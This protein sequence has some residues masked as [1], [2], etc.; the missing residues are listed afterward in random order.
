MKEIRSRIGLLVVLLL[1]LIPAVYVLADETESDSDRFT[2]NAAEIDGDVQLEDVNGCSVRLQVTN[3]GDD[4]E[5]TL[6]ILRYESVD[7]SYVSAVG[8]TVSIKSGETQNIYLKLSNITYDGTP[9]RI[10]LRVDFLDQDGQLLCRKITDFQAA[11]DITAKVAAGVYTDDTQKLSVIDKSRFRYE[12]TNISGDITM[13]ARQMSDEEMDNIKQ[14]NINLLILDKAISESTWENISEW[15]MYGGHAMMEQSVYQSLISKT[16]DESGLTDWGKGRILVYDASEWKGTMLL[17]SVKSLFGTTGIYALLAGDYGE[18]YWNVQ[19]ILNYDIVSKL[20]PVTIYLVILLIYILCIGPAVYIFLK[21][22]DKREYMWLWIPC[23]AVLF[24]VIAYKAGSGV[25]Y[26][27]PFIR[28]YSTVDVTD[29]ANIEK[30]KLLLISPNKGR[31]VFS[32]DSNYNLRLLNDMYLL[33]DNQSDRFAVL[34]KKFSNAEYNAAMSVSDTRTDVMVNNDTTFDEKHFSN[35]RIL[36]S[37]GGIDVDAAYYRGELMGTV[38]NTTPWSLHDAFIIHK[39]L[40]F[41]IGTLEANQTI[42]LD[43]LKEVQLVKSQNVILDTWEMQNEGNTTAVLAVMNSLISNITSASNMSL[44]DDIVG[45]FTMDYDIGVQSSEDV[46][47]VNGVTLIKEKTTV[48]DSGSGWSTQALIAPEEPEN[49]EDM[50]DYD[51][52]SYMLYG[53]DML[54]AA[55]TVELS[56]GNLYLKWLNPDSDMMVAFYNLSTGVYDT[57]LADS[58]EMTAD[59][60]KNYIADDGTI[61]AHVQ[62]GDMNYDHYM[63]V[64]TVSGG[65]KND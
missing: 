23:L 19:S 7:G 59:E 50:Y 34:E 12:T 17:K 55:Y 62:A 22:R 15:L 26:S 38:T 43:H 44:S 65:E 2:V 64:F 33:Y 28:F 41:Q 35:E 32:V 16:P 36:K 10:P 45:G 18:Y 57:V 37:E 4:F 29:E 60:L 30:T 40:L 1:I 42:T 14:L 6:K 3:Q 61:K 53:T 54:N 9:Y 13:K 46:A 27:E 25:R 51:T 39:G 52:D 47:S 31:S 5:G 49:E 58:D 48:A 56:S 21:K 63:P 11:P 8:R 24:S 20:P